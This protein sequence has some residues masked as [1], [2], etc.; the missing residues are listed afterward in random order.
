[1]KRY[2]LSSLCLFLI[3]FS[4]QKEKNSPVN[5]APIE[6][7]KN[8]TVKNGRLHFPSQKEL[9]TTELALNQEKP[10]DLTNWYKNLNFKSQQELYFEVNDAFSTV[11]N[12]ADYRAFQ[13]MYDEVIYISPRKSLLVKGYYPFL[14]PVL[15][16][17]GELYVGNALIKYTNTH[18]ITILDGAESKLAEAIQTLKTDEEKGIIVEALNFHDST[19][20]NRIGGCAPHLTWHDC[21]Y[22]S[23]ERIWGRYQ[24]ITGTPNFNPAWHSIY[25]YF[26]YLG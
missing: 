23:H 22:G 24:V 9:S 4:C 25:D 19:I 15:N 7:L 3:C 16:T 1:M 14:A 21:Y 20:N 8:V 18:K 13:A 12:E 2:F 26:P 10:I 6:V 11:Q 5:P 17:Q